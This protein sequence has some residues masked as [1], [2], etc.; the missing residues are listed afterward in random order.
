[1]GDAHLAKGVRVLVLSSGKAGHAANAVGV[2]EAL[3]VPYEV[4]VVAPRSVYSALSPYGPADPRDWSCR[5][6]S[7]MSKPGPAV[8]IACGR[9]TAPYLRALKRAAP[10]KVF[11]VFLQDPVASRRQF[12]LIWAPQHDRLSGPN[13]MSTLTSP[14]PF[15]AQRLLRERNSIDPR[16]ARLPSPRAAI[17]LGGPSGAHDF[18]PADNARMEEA[19]RQTVLQGFSIM[20]TP[21]RRT[22]PALLAAVKQ[23]L[24]DAPGFVW[25]GVGVNPYAQILANADA[26]LATADSVN[27]VGEAT[28][29]G[30]PVYLFE[31]SGGGRK[32]N[33]F[34]SA[35]EKLGV[36]RRFTGSLERFTYAPID[37]SETIASE[38]ARRFA[39]SNGARLPAVSPA[40]A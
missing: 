29:T 1:M 25:D 14:H 37:S 4:E 38:I 5:V 27:M 16:L 24:G 6:S 9:I 20:A 30:A 23:G 18:T 33:D 26:I 2:A 21:S 8:V 13:V 22:P 31:S 10:E 28:A 35:L 3:G 36:V 12:D 11:A 7:V 39:A 17:I 19:I 15:G 40:S 34:L 32:T